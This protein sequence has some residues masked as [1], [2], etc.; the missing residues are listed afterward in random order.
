MDKIVRVEDQQLKAKY[1][2]FNLVEKKI[3]GNFNREDV[4]EIVAHLKSLPLHRDLH[5]IVTVDTPF[6][7]R[8]GKMFSKNDAS[9]L[10]DEY[11]WEKRGSY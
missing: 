10:P 2:G 1:H 4:N 9:S 8:S 3:Y 7:F 11:D 5:L 6:G